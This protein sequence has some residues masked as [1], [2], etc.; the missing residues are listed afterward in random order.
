MYVT[1]CSFSAGNWVGFSQVSE[2]IRQ[3]KDS[4]W[5]GNPAAGYLFYREGG[6]L[7]METV[8]LR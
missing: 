2:D 4:Q 5:P 7:L 8:T 3:K 6:F 1:F